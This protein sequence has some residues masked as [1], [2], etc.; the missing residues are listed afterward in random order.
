MR[1]AE[2]AP[3]LLVIGH[4]RI[5]KGG[6]VWVKEKRGKDNKSVQNLFATW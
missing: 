6:L 4:G 5:V 1:D 3:E 2:L